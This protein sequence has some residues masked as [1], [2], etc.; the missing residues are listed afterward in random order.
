MIEKKNTNENVV[1]EVQTYAI[2][3]KFTLHKLMLHL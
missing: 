3:I 1:P 2:S